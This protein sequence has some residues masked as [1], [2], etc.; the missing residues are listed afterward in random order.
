MPLAQIYLFFSA[1]SIEFYLLEFPSL[2]TQILR[3]VWKNSS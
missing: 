1:A 3:I 2:E